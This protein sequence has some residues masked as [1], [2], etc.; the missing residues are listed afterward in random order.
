MSDANRR[1]MPDDQECR[2]HSCNTLHSN[3]EYKKKASKST[4]QYLA[5][6]VDH[7]LALRGD[8]PLGETTTC[9]DFNY[10]TDLV[11]ICP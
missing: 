11:K 8:I 9:G 5:E 1:S 2:N 3:Q 7:M 10:A 4:G 6:G